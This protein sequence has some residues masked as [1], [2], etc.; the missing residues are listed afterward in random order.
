MRLKPLAPNMTELTVSI[1]AFRGETKILF[2]Y[3]TPVAAIN[4]SPEF[5][6]KF[7]FSA[8]KTNELWST[9]TQRHI[10]KWLDGAEAT[11]VTQL[12]FDTLVNGGY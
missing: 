5:F 11:Q 12:V 2:S 1:A 9:T 4:L 8:I 7:G 10:N 6:E 3:E